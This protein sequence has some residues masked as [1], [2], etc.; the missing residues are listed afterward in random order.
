MNVINWQVRLDNIAG[1]A[2]TLTK[3][4]LNL[5][6]VPGLKSRHIKPVHYPIE[7]FVDKILIVGYLTATS[8]DYYQI[9]IFES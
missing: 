6:D 2:L 9:I 8:S 4:E 5:D 1:T 3:A 7:V